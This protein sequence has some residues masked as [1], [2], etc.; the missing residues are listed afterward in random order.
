M[1]ILTS[2]YTCTH[3]KSS[4]RMFRLHMQ[5]SKI[6]YAFYIRVDTDTS[7]C[8]HRSDFHVRLQRAQIQAFTVLAPASF[9]RQKNLY[10]CSAL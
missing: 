10:T 8:T 1:N 2:F 4:V 6:H 5:M 9:K 3:K 7:T